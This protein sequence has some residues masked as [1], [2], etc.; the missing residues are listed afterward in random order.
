MVK[1]LRTSTFLVALT[2]VGCQPSEDIAVNQ[3]CGVAPPD[4]TAVWISPED[5]V[6]HA[7][8]LLEWD[9][10]ER[11]PVTGPVDLQIRFHNYAR[12]LGEEEIEEV[13]SR[14]ELL[15][16]P[17]AKPI[18]FATEVTGPRNRTSSTVTILP[19]EDLQDGWYA[20][21]IAE[22]RGFVTEGAKRWAPGRGQLS[23]FH[24]GSCPLILGI[25]SSADS[26]RTRLFLSETLERSALESLSIASLDGAHS[27]I[28]RFST[29]GPL[30]PGK[31]LDFDCDFGPAA[32]GVRVI[33]DPSSPIILPEDV[34]ESRGIIK[35]NRFA[36]SPAEPMPDCKR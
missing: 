11:K 9:N 14:I 6:T 13:L 36:L 1:A 18:A 21:K 2:L 33:L 30:S 12:P 29:G 10:A 20:V 22:R 3:T 25:E 31:E 5:M 15:T 26:G 28:R 19:A 32:R 35:K 27:C 24:V 23:R 17:E 16:W 34:T 8:R 4:V 7:R